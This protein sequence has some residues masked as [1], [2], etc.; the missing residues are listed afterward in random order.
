[1]K[2]YLFALLSFFFVASAYAGTPNQVCP[3]TTITQAVHQVPQ[4]TTFYK[5]VQEPKQ[6]T[7]NTYREPK[8][9]KRVVAL[10]LCIFFGVLGLHRFYMGD[11]FI[12]LIQLF[13]AGSGGIWWLIDLFR[14]IFGGFKSRFL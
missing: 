3:A 14:L 13:T 1:M 8:A 6:K 10:L 4:K 12:G 5:V 11:T 2:N 9:R 7:E